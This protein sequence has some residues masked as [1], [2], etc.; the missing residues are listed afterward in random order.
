MTN[1]LA[2]VLVFLSILPVLNLSTSPCS[3]AEK[4]I[5]V[6]WDT[7]SAMV[8]NVIMA[9]LPKLRELAP[10]IKVRLHRELKDMEEAKKVFYESE[11]KV[12]GIVFL[13]SSGA[14]FLA[15]VKPRVPCFVG[16]TNHPGE[17][18]TIRNLN[19]PE[20]MITGVTYFIPYEK[21]FD[22]IDSLFPGIK[23]LALL[24]EK[25]HP[26]GP[27]EQAGTRQQCEARGIAYS[28]VIATNLNDLIEKTRSLGKTDLIVI[29]N[30]RL[31]MDNVASLLTV[32]NENNS[33]MFSYADKPVKS[34]AVAGIA[35]DDF[36]LG[37]M[38]A[39]SV[40]DVLV[41][42]KPISQEPVKMDPEP[43]ITINKAMAKHLGLKFPEAILKKAVFV[44]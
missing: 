38:L 23:T 13:R 6:I 39:E 37:A 19:A 2:I 16:A 33:P 9:F 34:G 20:G 25:G 31:V 44:E 11:S 32:A 12:D 30:T 18:G 24:V 40:V 26:S 42:G 28:E 8:S 10:E 41:K 7:K 29:S 22:V 21:R 5:A 14:Q 3:A 17:L 1:L 36:K 15:T 35:A 27:I 43:K 4:E